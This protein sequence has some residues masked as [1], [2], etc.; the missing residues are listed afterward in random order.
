MVSSA[1]KT[2][3]TLHLLWNSEKPNLS[4]GR[5]FRCTVYPHISNRQRLDKKA[6]KLVIQ[7]LPKSEMER[8]TR[9]TFVMTGFLKGT[10]SCTEKI[11]VQ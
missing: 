1:L 8:S 3:E 7:R 2:G 9:A 10:D 5:V 11:V 4:H 6:W